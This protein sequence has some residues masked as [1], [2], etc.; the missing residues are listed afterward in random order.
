MFAK[1]TFSMPCC[2]AITITC[3]VRVPYEP[4]DYARVQP[5]YLSSFVSL[6]MD[7]SSVSPSIILD[8]PTQKDCTGFCIGGNVE[9]LRDQPPA[10][11]L[12]DDLFYGQDLAKSLEP[13][14]ANISV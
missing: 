3:A 8:N 10:M 1:V 5:I 13:V 6:G 2:G 9:F 7:R 4:R 14:A 12:G 11:V